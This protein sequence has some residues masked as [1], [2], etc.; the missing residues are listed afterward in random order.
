[1]LVI[2]NGR[3]SMMIRLVLFGLVAFGVWNGGRL[4][5][6]HYHSGEACPILK[7]VPACYIAFSGYLMMAISLMATSVK[8]KLDVTALFWVGLLVA[9]GLALIGTGFELVKGDVCPKAFGWL[10][11]CYVSLAFSVLTGVLY[12]TISRS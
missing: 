6:L 10:P 8:I 5:Y 7:V 12:A 11:M 4:S 1:M 3:R 2:S 9:G